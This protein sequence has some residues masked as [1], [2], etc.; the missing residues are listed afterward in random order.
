M[1]ATG[2][3]KPL[4]I[5]GTVMSLAGAL[6]MTTL[7]RH[8][9]ATGA[10]IA[11]FFPNTGTGLSNPAISVS[12]LAHSLKEDQAVMSTTQI[13]FRGLGTVMGVALSRMITQ[14][15]LPRYLEEYVGG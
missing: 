8:T 4:I 13:L 6:A 3:P 10:T 14:S 9:A 5:T 15:A 11:F 1:N 7:P 2:N 12:N